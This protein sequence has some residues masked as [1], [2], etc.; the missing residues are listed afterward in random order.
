[1]CYT[2]HCC[3]G[4]FKN[5]SDGRYDAHDNW[6]CDSC[7][8][9]EYHYCDDCGDLYPNDELTEIDGEYFCN[10][11]V[12]NHRCSDSGVCGYHAHHSEDP[13]F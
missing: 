7:V 13:I 11:C 3:G 9:S 4:V 8:G 2:C 12:E 1:M 6:I 10:Y 5:E